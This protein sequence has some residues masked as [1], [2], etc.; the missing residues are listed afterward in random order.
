MTYYDM[1]DVLRMIKYYQKG[2]AVMR[3]SIGRGKKISQ[4]PIVQIRPR[5]IRQRKNYSADQ[6]QELAL[7]VRRHGI[8][9]PVLVRRTDSNEY[10]LI[11]GE[12]RL[13]AAA[14]CG[15]KKIPCIVF[16]CS[17]REAAVY[18]LSENIQRCPLDPFE[19]A[20]SI[21]AM[22]KHYG[23]NRTEV[24]ARLGKKASLVAQ[25][26]NL[27]RFTGDE[28]DIITKY[29]LTDRH[30]LALLRLND[31][32]RRKMA[33]SEIIERGLNVSQTEEYI[34]GILKNKK[35]EHSRRQKKC[36]VIKD[37]K[38]LENTINKAVDTIRSSGIRASSTQTENDE[39]VEYTVRIPK[40]PR[41]IDKKVSA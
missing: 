1:N 12:R 25:R 5:S 17:P 34:S 15:K 2:S 40:S 31:I 19:E 36:P 33:L 13:R 18:A 32:I 21:S 27:L 29:R 37:I 8:L 9:E 24:S 35:T 6:M 7:S 30:A 28:K 38:I 41:N 10:E 4:I 11:S 14:M 23:L 3:F 20:D 26:L 39:F 16:D 22:I